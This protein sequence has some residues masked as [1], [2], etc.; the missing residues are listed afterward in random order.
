MTDQLLDES[1]S[2]GRVPEVEQHSTSPDLPGAS[3]IGTGHKPSESLAFGV[4]GG[5]G[6]AGTFQQPHRFL[7]SAI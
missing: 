6:E 2:L 5:S 4:N 3:G 7:P 1:D